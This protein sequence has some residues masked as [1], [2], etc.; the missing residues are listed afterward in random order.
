MLPNLFKKL[1]IQNNYK[2][3]SRLVFAKR[4]LFLGDVGDF[5]MLVFG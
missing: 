2:K 5:L 4:G 3:Q 1:T